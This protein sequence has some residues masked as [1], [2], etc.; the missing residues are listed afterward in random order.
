MMFWQSLTFD[1]AGD[2]TDDQRGR[3]LKIANNM[4]TVHRTLESSHTRTGVDT[5]LGV[6]FRR[7]Q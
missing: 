5:T 6:F 4:C 2:L 7:K 3:I 1:L